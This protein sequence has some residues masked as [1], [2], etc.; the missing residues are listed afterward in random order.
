M[1]HTPV[2]DEPPQAANRVRGRLASRLGQPAGASI[3]PPSAAAAHDSQ[4]DSTT[5]MPRPPSPDPGQFTPAGCAAAAAP[6]RQSYFM[7]T[8]RSAIHHL[9][10]VEHTARTAQAHADLGSADASTE[11]EQAARTGQPIMDLLFV[12]ASASTEAFMQADR[13]ATSSALA[14]RLTA[15]HTARLHDSHMQQG[16]MHASA[17]PGDLGRGQAAAADPD[18]WLQPAQSPSFGAAPG[19]DIPTPSQVPPSPWPMGQASPEQQQPAPA[20]RAGEVTGGHPAQHSAHTSDQHAPTPAQPA[21][22]QGGAPQSAEVLPPPDYTNPPGF[23]QARATP[24]PPPHT[25]QCAGTEGSPASAAAQTSG[26]Q[27]GPPQPPPHMAGQNTQQTGPPAAAPSTE[28]AC[29]GVDTPKWC[30]TIRAPGYKLIIYDLPERA[31]SAH[32]P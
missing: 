16:H 14:A 18:P 22:N 27:L 25:G 4:A 17:Q 11:L 2:S 3:C 23:W 30:Q 12:W 8:L 26:L 15:A 19:S 32:V 7:A 29:A 10:A 28:R 20:G 31:T 9:E 6:R 1:I 5:N 13:K 24:Q 21:S